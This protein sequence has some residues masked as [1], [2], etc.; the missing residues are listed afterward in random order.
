MLEDVPPASTRQTA[1]RPE[2]APSALESGTGYQT[3]PS[4][5][6]PSFS[7]AGRN[8][9]PLP[10]SRSARKKKKGLFRRF[11][12]VGP[13]IGIALVLVAVVAGAAYKMSPSGNGADPWGGCPSCNLL[14]TM[15][16][17]RWGAIPIYP[18]GNE[19]FLGRPAAPT[20]PWACRPYPP[21]ERK[22]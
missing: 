4:R 9:G 6:G 12:I 16:L 8:T 7:G 17:A 5:K 11:G 19:G 3:T 2:R 1:G 21:G 13:A 14:S 18:G 22:T 20:S 15:R 10:G